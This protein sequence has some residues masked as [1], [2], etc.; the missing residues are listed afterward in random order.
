MLLQSHD[1]AIHLLPAL[2]KAWATGRFKG[3]RARGGFEVDAAW[4][5]GRLTSATIRSMVGGP[6]R[7]RAALPL[8]VRGEAGPVK[9]ES[10][11]PNVTVFPSEASKSYALTPQQ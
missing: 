6:C 11:E 3:L 7:V 1:G 9:A 8:D 4:R 5:D 10:P 2:P